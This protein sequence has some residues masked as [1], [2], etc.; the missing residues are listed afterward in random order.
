M[1]NVVFRNID[2]YAISH[3]LKEI[4]R[5]ALHKECELLHLPFPKRLRLFYLESNENCTFLKYKYQT[6]DRAVMK[7]DRYELPETGWIRVKLA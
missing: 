2:K 1:N 7:I 6:G 3:L 4:G 5:H